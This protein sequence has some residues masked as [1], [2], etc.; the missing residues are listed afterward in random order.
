MNQSTLQNHSLRLSSLVRQTTALLA[1]GLAAATSA[2]ATGPTVFLLPTTFANGTSGSAVTNVYGGV[3]ALGG[4]SVYLNAGADPGNSIFPYTFGQGFTVSANGTTGAG[5]GAWGY[6]GGITETAINV[7]TTIPI[8]YNFT[9]AK[10]SGIHGDV[11]WT[12]YFRGGGGPELSIASGTLLNA[13][14]AVAT[15][16]N[17]SGNA[18]SYTF[19]SGASVADTY[20][21]YINISYSSNAGA[22]LPG[23][24]TVSMSDTGFGGPGITLNASAIPE[25]STYAAIVGALALVGVMLQRRRQRLAA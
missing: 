6:Q 1:A 13:G 11:D 17:F 9:V 24:V 21:A 14:F 12:L 25:P 5:T 18:S 2:L 15:S 16:M 7:G 23:V 10:N 8:S 20:R 22:A 4:S 19:T 3:A